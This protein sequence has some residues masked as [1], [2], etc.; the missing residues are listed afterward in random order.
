MYR[1]GLYTK[2]AIK[3]RRVFR[4]LVREARE[5]LAVRSGDAE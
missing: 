2:E 1:H 5:T 3:E 4:E